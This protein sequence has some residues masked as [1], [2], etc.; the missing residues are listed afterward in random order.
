VKTTLEGKRQEY[1]GL[2]LSRRRD[3]VILMLRLPSEGRVEN[4]L[5][6]AGTLSIGYFWTDRPYNVYH[7]MTPGGDTLGVYFNIGDQTHITAEAVYWR[8]LAVDIL[9]TPD[10]RFRSLDEEELPADLD[11]DLRTMIVEVRKDL[12]SRCQELRRELEARST[13]FLG[14][15]DVVTG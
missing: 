4:L 6:P 7:W 2:L 11:C 1:E 15:L 10:G 12:L 3:E 9:V 5:L 14:E 13:R 8:D